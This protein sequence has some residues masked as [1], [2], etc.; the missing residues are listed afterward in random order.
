VTDFDLWL[1]PLAGP[2]KPAS[3]LAAP[4]DQLHA[5]FSPDGKLLAYS[6]SES[7]RFEIQVQTFP[8]SDRKWTVSTAGGSEPRW[9]ADGGELYYLA[10]ER[11]LMAVPVGPGPS[12]GVPRQLFL[13]RAPGGVNPLRSRYVPSADGSRFLIN[14][15]VAD[16]APTP[17]TIVLNWTA[18][19]QK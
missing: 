12:F 19:L 8:L 5:A 16:P 7:G 2:P 17:I 18:D 10:D 14:T 6:S 9:R 3:L 1:L 4:G 13:T 11:R 15:Q